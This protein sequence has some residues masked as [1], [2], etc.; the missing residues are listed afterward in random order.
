MLASKRNQVSIGMTLVGRMA[1]PCQL[2]NL[3]DDPASTVTAHRSQVSQSGETLGH[4]HIL[5]G[6]GSDRTP[7]L[8]AHRPGPP[9]RHDTNGVRA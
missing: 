3:R 9:V 7:G 2:R 1:Q 4:P 6:N 5:D 8:G